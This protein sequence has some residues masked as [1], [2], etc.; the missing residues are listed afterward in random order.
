MA[1]GVVLI[2]T[3]APTRFHKSEIHSILQKLS[4]WACYSVCVHH[5]STSRR[6]TTQAW[7]LVKSR[8]PMLLGSFLALGP[9]AGD[10]P[11]RRSLRRG[12]PMEA[13]PEEARQ[14]WLPPPPLLKSLSEEAN[15]SDSTQERQ[16]EALSTGEMQDCRSLTLKARCPQSSQPVVLLSVCVTAAGIN[17]YPHLDKRSPTKVTNRTDPSPHSHPTLRDPEQAPDRAHGS[18]AG[19][20]LSKPGSDA[21]A[22]AD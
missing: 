7:P 6:Q 15:F 17:P 20:V 19:S 21:R 12:W 9:C 13:S 11:G 16:Q 3:K 10:T 14:R 5:N 1:K 4:C 2:L 18:R 8:A 22:P